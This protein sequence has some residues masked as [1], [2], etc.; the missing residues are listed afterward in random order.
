[1]IK[2]SVLPYGA[3]GV[4]MM[5]FL[6][7]DDARMGQAATNQ[8][9]TNR[10]ATNRAGPLESQVATALVCTTTSLSSWSSMSLGHVRTFRSRSPR[11]RLAEA[12]RR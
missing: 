10:G 3:D 7:V 5:G 2:T 12:P 4:R 8:A 11:R 6:A 9:A 1:M